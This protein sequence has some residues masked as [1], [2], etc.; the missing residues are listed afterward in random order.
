MSEGPDRTAILQALDQ[1]IDPKSGKG[2][3]A[4]GLVRGVARRRRGRA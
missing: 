1:V 3:T 2:L 4:A